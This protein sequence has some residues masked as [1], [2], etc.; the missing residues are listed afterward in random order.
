[1]AVERLGDSIG[2]RE[3]LIKKATSL[4]FKAHKS[5]EKPYLLEKIRSS[6]LIITFSGSWTIPDWFSDNNFGE[7]P[8]NLT[9]FPSLRSIGND[10]PALVNKA[11]LLRFETILNNSS[12][13]SDVNKAMAEKKKIVFAGHSSGAPMAILASLWTLEH[14]RNASNPPFCVTFGSPLIGNHILP[15][16]TRREDWSRYFVHFLTRYDVVPRI[17]L[18]PLSSLHHETLAAILHLFNPKSKPPSSSAHGRIGLAEFYGGVTRNAAAVTS[19][20]ACS[21]MG[22]TNLLL[23]TV[24]SL[25]V[26]SPYRPFG[27]FVW[28]TGNG[29]MVVVRNSEA[30]S[31]EMQSVVY[32]EKLEDLPLSGDC[33]A[34][35]NA[36]TIDQALNDLGL[37]TRAR[38][39]MRAAGELEKQKSRNEAKIDKAKAESTMKELEDYK[40]VSRI[41]GVG[42]YDAFKLQKEPRDFQA[43]VK[44]LVLAGV[45]DE[46]IEMLKR[47][48]LPDE[49]EG[50]QEWIELGTRFRRLV[51]PLDI[52]N[53]YRHLKNEDT[54]P[55]MVRARP[56]RYR[57]TQRWLEHARRLPGGSCSESCF[58]AEVEELSVFKSN[59]GSSY[60]EE[61]KRRVVK[62]EEDVKRWSEEEL[63]RDVFLEGS[64]FTKW[65]KKLPQ[66]YKAGILQC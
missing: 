47:H 57:Y 3:E 65:W 26:L 16:A 49:F 42:Y 36:A 54:G 21:L 51:E 52:G 56:K 18:S 38:L 24:A 11:F 33:N 4:A 12:L 20:R 62:L 2:I 43:N 8:I 1:M 25:V 9:L 50:K 23:E 44:R 27:T 60:D 31:L 63:P 58:W 30:E 34:D 66:D 40:E 19:H 6:E 10:E 46:V 39:C 53:Y 13:K 48:E 32:L 45:W 22:S 28:C 55:Y 59:K 61:L 64:S 29:R 41:Q 7:T 37:G 15:H 35:D 14:H 5:P 17:S